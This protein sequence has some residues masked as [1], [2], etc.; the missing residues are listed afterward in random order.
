MRLDAKEKSSL[1]LM[2]AIFEIAGIALNE[3]FQLF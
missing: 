1:T 2:S 3:D